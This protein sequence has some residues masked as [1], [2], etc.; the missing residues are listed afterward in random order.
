MA[1]FENV[2]ARKMSGVTGEPASPV[3]PTY[4]LA[5]VPDATAWTGHLIIIS[6]ATPQCLAYSD[7]TNWIATDDGTTAA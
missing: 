3:I 5:T 1:R 2:T 7:G 6:D 4:T